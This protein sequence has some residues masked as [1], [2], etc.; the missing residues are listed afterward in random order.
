MPQRRYLVASAIVVL[1][2]ALLPLAGSRYAV[3]LAQY[4]LPSMTF[5]SR[6]RK[7]GY[8]VVRDFDRIRQL[9]GERAEQCVGVRLCL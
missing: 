3:D 2:L 8:L 7:T 1:L 6:T 9:I 5:D 4:K